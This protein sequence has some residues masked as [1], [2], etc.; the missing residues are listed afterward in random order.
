MKTNSTNR[1][2]L[3]WLCAVL[4]YFIANLQKVVMPGAIF[5]ELQEHFSVAAGSIT[6]VGAVFMY[7]YAVS[8]LIVGLLVDRFS[9]ARVM[10]WGGLVL[11]GG[12]LLSA[13]AP[14]LWVLYI[15]RFMVGFG[16]ASIYLSITKETSRIYPNSFAMMLG[17]VMVGG[18][19][20][21]V[22]GN[23][24]FI[25][26]VQ[27]MGWQQALLLVGGLATLIYLAYT[28]LKFT[29]PMPGI[30]QTAKFDYHR[31]FE[32]LKLRQ[33]LYIIICGG[34]PFGLY[35][36]IQSIFGKKFL[37]DYSG[38]TPEGAGWVLT[39]LMII[40]AA[41]SLLAPALSKLAGNRRRPLMLFSGMGTAVA[42]LLIVA[43]L[44]L[45]IHSP[46]LIG[47]AFILLAFAGNISPV[48]VALVRESNRSD[49]WGVMLSVYAFLAYIVTAV[50]GNSTG[51]IMELFPPQ[52]VDGIHIYGKNSYLAVFT[53]LLVCSLFAAYSG[54]RLKESNGKDISNEIR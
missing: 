40:G 34:F 12:S 41:N 7:T 11:C 37:E 43:G 49:I 22:M 38:M 51:W 8:Q 54:F 13:V 4:L 18:Y 6:G 47:G 15:A 29:L 20:G 10:A 17:F 48:I 16:A 31:F 44:L 26:G 50:I 39:A 25:A 9:G 23:A 28:G 42:F 35:F 46:W 2:F 19:L 36:A 27:I 14:S 1:L 5:N 30:V 52:V 45:E 53:V 33:N 24:P 32:V 21:G 3:F